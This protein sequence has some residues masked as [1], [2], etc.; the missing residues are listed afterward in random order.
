[1][2]PAGSLVCGYQHGSNST[3]TEAVNGPNCS[4][5]D[6]LTGRSDK[7]DVLSPVLR[8]QRHVRLPWSDCLT[9]PCIPAMACS[10]LSL[11]LQRILLQHVVHSNFW[12]INTSLCYHNQLLRSPASIAVISCA[13]CCLKSS[14]VWRRYAGLC[15]LVRNQDSCIG[16]R[17]WR[18]RCALT[19]YPCD[20]AS[21][22][23]SPR[24]RIRA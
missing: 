16:K 13:V 8:A 15:D 23:S 9:F 22:W 3:Q 24:T 2:I 19:H 14:F 6:D 7:K 17:R 10:H 21:G 4:R 18:R 11:F 5:L 20:S 12:Q 1:L